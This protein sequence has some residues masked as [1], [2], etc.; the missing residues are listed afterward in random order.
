MH[1][2]GKRLVLEQLKKFVFKDHCAFGGGDVFADLKNAFI[3]HG[4]MALLHVVHQVLQ[5][6]GNALALGVQRFFLGFG[7][8]SQEIARGAGRQPLLYRKAHPCA[9]F[10]IAFNGFRQA[11]QCLCIDHVA[12]ST[13]VRDRVAVPGLAGKAA[14][15][16]RL[17]LGRISRHAGIPQ[18]TGLLQV[19]LLDFQQFGRV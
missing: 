19:G 14:V 15:G 13:K 4:D 8:Q 2:G 16:H 10:F 12:G 5:A 3:G 6:L 18:V 7:I 17:E 1:L 9:G 11:H